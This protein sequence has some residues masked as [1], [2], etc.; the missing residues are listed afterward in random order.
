MITV[1]QRTRSMAILIVLLMSTIGCQSP[2]K[3]ASDFSS[4]L[5]DP[6]GYVILR[7]TVIDATS[8]SNVVGW[9]IAVDNFW[10]GR[11]KSKVG[12]TEREA[13]TPG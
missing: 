9:T 2:D 10:G 4:V 7:G 5:P 3:R 12:V 1:I 8:G 11:G 13:G 6:K